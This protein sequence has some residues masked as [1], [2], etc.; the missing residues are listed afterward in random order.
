[1]ID[2]VKAAVREMMDLMPR[3]GRLV[4]CPECDSRF[5]EIAIH[6]SRNI[7]LA[8]HLYW[9]HEFKTWRQLTDA[10]NK[11]NGQGPLMVEKGDG[12]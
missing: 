1:M 12:G 2:E 7:M 3:T 6:E 5:M 8:E 4:Q 11:V 10:L 9:D